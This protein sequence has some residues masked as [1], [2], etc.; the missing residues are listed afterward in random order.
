MDGFL[1]GKK[2]VTQKRS[3]YHFENY[4]FEARI[5]RAIC[6]YVIDCRDS[7]PCGSC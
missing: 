5:Q 6:D 2:E 1:S 7:F 4:C 3:K